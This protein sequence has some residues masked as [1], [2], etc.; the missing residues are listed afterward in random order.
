MKYILLYFRLC[1]SSFV[2]TISLEILLQ[3]VA[4]P[5]CQPCR[6]VTDKLRWKK[7][8]LGESGNFLCER[9]GVTHGRD[10][11]EDV[12]KG[13][14]LLKHQR[15]EPWERVRRR[16]KRLLIHHSVVFIA[17]SS[18]SYQTSLSGG[19]S[20][21]AEPPIAPRDRGPDPEARSGSSSPLA[22]TPPPG[23]SRCARPSVRD[24]DELLRGRRRCTLK[25]RPLALR[26]GCVQKEGRKF[27]TSLILRSV[28]KFRPPRPLLRLQ[29][30]A[31]PLRWR[32]WKSVV[33]FDCS[34]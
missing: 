15:R 22:L 30:D 33:Q 4:N 9:G 5:K 17:N 12:V 34:L 18:N 19:G 29:S 20:T 23:A 31:V 28:T 16:R 3:S 7:N 24:N 2:S 26:L 6:I 14:L 10:K 13:R 1:L 21:S 8:T 27:R 11:G 32:S 25:G